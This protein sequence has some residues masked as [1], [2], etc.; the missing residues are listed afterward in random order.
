MPTRGVLEARAIQL[1]SLEPEM[2]NAE[3]SSGCVR[4]TYR[5]YE[6]DAWSRRC[7][8]SRK[9]IAPAEIFY[10]TVDIGR[11]RDAEERQNLS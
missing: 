5:S 3:F 9:R 10:P 1:A 7:P 2:L 6:M 11:R 8:G 4:M